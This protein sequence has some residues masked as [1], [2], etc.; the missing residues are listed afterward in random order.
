MNTSFSNKY[1]LTKKL[2]EGQ[3]GQVFMGW[4]ITTSEHAA[5]KVIKILSDTPSTTNGL[6]NKLKTITEEYR[7]LS[8]LHHPNIVRVVG[9][10]VTGNEAYIYMEWMQCGSVTQLMKQ[11]GSNFRLHERTVRKFTRDVLLGLAYLH[12]KGVI[13]RDIK[14]DNFLVASDGTVKL[15]DFGLCKHAKK[16]ST[17]TIGSMSSVTTTSTLGGGNVAGTPNYMAPEV[18]TENV[19]RASDI[20]ALGAAV[21]HMASGELPW[22]E[23]GLP[24]FPLMFAIGKLASKS[25]IEGGGDE[26]KDGPLHPRLPQYLSD[27]GIDFVKKCFI[28]DPKKRPSAKELLE[29]P[30]VKSLNEDD[31]ASC[32]V[33]GIDHYMSEQRNKARN[34]VE[35]IRL[36]VVS[37]SNALSFNDSTTTDSWAG[38]PTTHGQFDYSVSAE[39]PQQPDYFS[40]APAEIPLEDAIRKADF[41]NYVVC[42]VCQTGVALHSLQSHFLSL[43]DGK[44]CP[45]IPMKEEWVLGLLQ[46]CPKQIEKEQRVIFMYSFDTPLR[47]E[48]NASMRAISGNGRNP[49]HDTKSHE[50]P[51]VTRYHYFLRLLVKQLRPLPDYNA[52]G[53][54]ALRFVV[55]HDMY[56]PGAIVTWNQPSSISI[57]ANDI[58][59]FLHEDTVSGKVSGTI[60]V[61]KLRHGKNVSQYSAYPDCKEVLVLPNT[62]FRVIPYAGDG[63]K[64]LLATALDSDL[65][66]VSVLEVHEVRLN[67]WEDIYGAS[68]NYVLQ[69][70]EKAR[71]ASILQNLRLADENCEAVYR[72]AKDWVH[73][74]NDRRKQCLPLTMIPYSTLLRDLYIAGAGAGTW[75]LFLHRLTGEQIVMC[76]F[77]DESTVLDKLLQSTRLEIRKTSHTAMHTVSQYAHLP[78]TV[79]AASVVI[80]KVGLE[81]MI[82]LSQHTPERVEDVACVFAGAGCF[83]SLRRW[84]DNVSAIDV[85]LPLMYAAMSTAPCAADCVSILLGE[86]K[87]PSKEPPRDVNGVTPAHVAAYHGNSL[88]VSLFAEFGTKAKC[89]EWINAV[90]VKGHSTLYVACL[91]GKYDTVKYLINTAPHLV[92]IVPSNC[93]STPLLCAAEMGYLETVRLIATEAPQLLTR[94]DTTGRSPLYRAATNGHLDVVKLLVDLEPGLLNLCRNGA[95]SSLHVAAFSGHYD[96]VKFL[97]EKRCDMCRWVDEFNRSAL[98]VA[99]LNGHMDCVRFLLE[100]EEL[101]HGAEML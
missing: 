20:W 98:Y 69:R 17:Q 32:G 6:G 50:E 53:Y 80:H 31:E 43:H 55:S 3:Y 36:E 13:H 11:T 58:R 101:C 94:C 77:D 61:V 87:Q 24:V 26:T 75:A 51:F 70:E 47:Y 35:Q 14:P 41:T 27:N 16:D 23:L 59:D 49:F 89:P 48:A 57:D 66:N 62:Q 22:A 29:H 40:G 72:T 84:V 81:T 12:D 83:D 8:Q 99:C 25:H 93:E 30:F 71:L 1:V 5:V 44:I 2:G 95:F 52:F 64:A 54:R 78:Q 92:N 56:F 79:E 82:E 45:T 37:K 97:V 85:S 7:L 96:I 46:R 34:L 39:D 90:T 67:Y 100:D 19:C 38:G 86:W 15:S 76:A 68:G 88:I 21:V 60:F 74:G 73:G 42:E 4:D 33:E 63:I 91:N 28:I 9:F 65:S 18:I 10:E